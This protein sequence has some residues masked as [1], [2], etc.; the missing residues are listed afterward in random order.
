[1]TIAIPQT[2]PAPAPQ[3]FTRPYNLTARIVNAVMFTFCTFAALVAMSLLLCITGYVL[4]RGMVAFMPGI[5]QL[6]PNISRFGFFTGIS[7]SFPLFSHLPTETPTGMRNSIAGTALLI[8]ASSCLGVPLGILCGVYLAEFARD[9]YFTR[10]V[11]LLVDVL[12]GTPSIIVGVLAYQLVVVP[13]GTPSG[14]AGVVALAFMMVPIIART[15]EEMLKLVP[16]AYREASTGVGASQSQTLFRVTLPAAK[17]GIITGIMLAVARIAGET[18]PLYFTTFGSNL[19]VVHISK[20]SVL[21]QGLI[22]AGFL[23]IGGTVSARWSRKVY[24]AT[25]ILAGLAGV[26]SV[27]M[28][29]INLFLKGVQLNWFGL[30]YPAAYFDKPY[31][32]LTVQVFEN[33]TSAEPSWRDS[34][35][36]GMLILI[37][38]ITA[39]NL[40]VR[41]FSRSKHGSGGH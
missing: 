30:Q 12:A 40:A 15:T 26:V 3:A 17:S 25:M 31:P 20:E 19:P 41:F 29:G 11:R 4:Y 9:N 39:L 33:A 7:E 38:L 24:K 35:W 1:M 27:L 2:D 10:S 37:L 28:A 14:W 5:Q 23:I 16:T 6:G 18:A 22:I 8:F 34:A 13:M 36:G 21:I 32:T